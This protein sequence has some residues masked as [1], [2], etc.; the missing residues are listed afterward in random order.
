VHVDRRAFRT[1]EKL[2]YSPELGRVGRDD[3]NWVGSGRVGVR[4]SREAHVPGASSQPDRQRRAPVSVPVPL[5]VPF[6]ALTLLV[7]R[8]EGH[9]A[10]EKT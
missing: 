6:S 9:P 4:T 1:L 2:M 3:E 7:G 10:C 5:A 8:Q